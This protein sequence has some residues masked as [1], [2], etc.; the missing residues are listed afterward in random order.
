MSPLTHGAPGRPSRIRLRRA[1]SLADVVSI[2]NGMPSGE[3]WLSV[4]SSP[5]ARASRS[6][7]A[8]STF[9]ASGTSSHGVP[10]PVPS[11][12]R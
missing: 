8:A 9:T 12:P 1:R 7:V 11:T 3:P 6:S 5:V 10:Q 2:Q 4:T